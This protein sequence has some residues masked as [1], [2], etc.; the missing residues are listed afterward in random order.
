M[1]R[2]LL[3]RFSLALDATSLVFIL[4][5]CAAILVDQFTYSDV[6]VQLISLTWYGISLVVGGA[7]VLLRI[8]A[9]WWLLIAN[10]VLG[11][12][13]AVY[14]SVFYAPYPEGHPS[15]MP[16]PTTVLCAV[17]IASSVVLAVYNPWRW[18]NDRGT[19]GS[20]ERAER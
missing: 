16:W 4:L 7:C 18:R 10:A 1:R 20:Q 11:P 3:L 15:G 13:A 5:G 19:R 14:A 12:V 17:L 2:R 6:R 9:G 8:A